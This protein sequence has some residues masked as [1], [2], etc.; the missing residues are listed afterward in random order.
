M[1]SQT[2]ST[3]N[4]LFAFGLTLALSSLLMGCVQEKKSPTIT[5]S[6]SI[7]SSVKSKFPQALDY[8]DKTGIR[9]KYSAQVQH[10]LNQFNGKLLTTRVHAGDLCIKDDKFY[11]VGS[12]GYSSVLFIRL[13]AESSV[14]EKILQQKKGWEHVVVFRQS[15]VHQRTFTVVSS[16]DGNES[17]I[18]F[19][20]S[21]NWEIRGELIYIESTSPDDAME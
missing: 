1:K 7:L 21:P 8:P 14:V 6:E 18:Y 19:D 2:N 3:T 11:F 13:E 10:S 15:E 5:R 9:G 12:L 20:I 16:I 17:E 4:F